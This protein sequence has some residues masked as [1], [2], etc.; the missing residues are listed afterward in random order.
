MAGMRYTAE[1]R[2][3]DWDNQPLEW[4]VVDEDIGPCG[5]AI[6]FNLTE[7]EAKDEAYKLNTKDKA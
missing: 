2:G 1:H 5:S 6:T 3:G 4:C 7:Q